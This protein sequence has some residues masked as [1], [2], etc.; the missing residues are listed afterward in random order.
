METVGIN[1]LRISVINIPALRRVFIPYTI[2]S[3]AGRCTHFV[4]RVIQSRAAE[5]I[6]VNL[7]TFPTF[8]NTYYY[9]DEFKLKIYRFYWAVKGA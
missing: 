9:C 6:S 7:R 2:H 4:R 3:E 5:F 8:P 1:R